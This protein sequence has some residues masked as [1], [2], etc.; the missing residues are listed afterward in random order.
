MQTPPRSQN[1]ARRKQ[2]LLSLGR[3]PR[4][5]HQVANLVEGLMLEKQQQQAQ[6]QQYC[7][8]DG[9]SFCCSANGAPS[10]TSHPS[11]R[12]GSLGDEDR[13]IESVLSSAP[14]SPFEAYVPTSGSQPV[15]SRFRIDPAV[16]GLEEEEAWFPATSHRPRSMSSSR[17][18]AWRVGKELKRSHSNEM[19]SRPIRVRVRSRARRENSLNAR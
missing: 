13:G 3:T 16:N 19:V 11:T 12:S 18:C 9:G 14:H 15:L 1:A 5:F 2:R 17:C 8:G 10:I 4:H 6:L 7:M